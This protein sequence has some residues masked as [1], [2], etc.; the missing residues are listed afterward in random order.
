VRKPQHL[1]ADEFDEAYKYLT[2][3]FVAKLRGLLKQAI[4][5]TDGRDDDPFYRR[6]REAGMSIDSWE[7]WKEGPLEERDGKLI[8][9]DIDK[10]E[11]GQYTFDRAL[12]TTKYSRNGS[13]REFGTAI[14]YQGGFLTLQGGP[15]YTL[16]RAGL[17]VK[18]APYNPRR[19]WQVLAGKQVVIDGSWVSYKPRAIYFDP[20]GQATDS[21]IEMRAQLGIEAWSP[22]V[23]QK[24]NETVELTGDH[25]IHL[26]GTLEGVLKDEGTNQLA[27]ETQYKIDPERED[28]I[29][30][31]KVGEE[32][33]RI[34]LSEAAPKAVIP[35]TTQLR[36]T[37]PERR[38]VIIDK[39]LSPEVSGGELTFDA[40]TSTVKTVIK[41]S[42]IDVSMAKTTPTFIRDIEVQPLAK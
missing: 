15:L 36:I 2:P 16:R 23:K 19:I 30:E 11:G 10:E 29:I 14:Y 26:S 22:E 34:A 38:L 18:V 9:T 7:L 28:I 21:K 35:P 3:E 32:W 31:A 25:T 33:Q 27:I 17:Q 5:K 8:R 37:R 13:P 39:Y 42:A 41:L 6:V 20:A 1:H 40:K 24:A 4:T 12:E